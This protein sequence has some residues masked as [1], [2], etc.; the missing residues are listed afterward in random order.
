M[1]TSGEITEGED[2]STGG[3]NTEKMTLSP[4]QVHV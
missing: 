2:T 3:R 4:P 1:A